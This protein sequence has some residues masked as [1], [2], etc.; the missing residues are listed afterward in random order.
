[1]LEKVDGVI[2]ALPNGAD[3]K[4]LVHAKKSGA[5]TE[6]SAKR[7]IE[8]SGKFKVKAFVAKKIDREI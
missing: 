2:V 1:M 4:V 6:D 8:K 7:I 3:H 5:L